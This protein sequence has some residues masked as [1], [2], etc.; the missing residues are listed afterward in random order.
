MGRD[1][2]VDTATRSSPGGGES[3]RTP[4]CRPWGP[5][6]LLYNG[7]QVS[8]SGIKRPSCGVDHPPSSTAKLKARE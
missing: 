6:S 8:F 4:L 2:V 5:P 1:S 3:S 7:Y